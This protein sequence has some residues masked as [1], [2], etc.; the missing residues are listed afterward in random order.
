ME[1]NNNLEKLTKEEIEKCI[2]ILELLNNDVSQL[3]E[4]QEETRVSLMMAAGKFT[5]PS[6]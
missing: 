5:R 4:L 1:N 2:S 6:L 3:F